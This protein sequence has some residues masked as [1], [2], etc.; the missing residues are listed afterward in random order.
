MVSV[1]YLQSVCA[2]LFSNRAVNASV[3]FTRPGTASSLLRASIIREKLVPDV[4]ENGNLFSL[5]QFVIYFSLQES[6][7]VVL[8]PSLD[9]GKIKQDLMQGNDR[10]KGLLLQALRWR[11]TR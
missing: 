2:R 4:F 10:T 5:R 6:E 1:E 7:E 8:L 9:Y 3:D 11:L